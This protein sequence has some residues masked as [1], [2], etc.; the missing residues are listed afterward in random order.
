MD[1]EACPT[2]GTPYAVFRDLENKRWRFLCTCE[3][4]ARCSKGKHPA[5]HAKLNAGGDVE[6]FACDDHGV[7][8]D[9]R[10]PTPVMRARVA[11]E[12]APTRK[13]SPS[14]PAR[15]AHDL[16][17]LEGF[18]ADL[19]ERN[20]RGRCAKCGRERAMIDSDFRPVKG[21]PLY[22]LHCPHCGHYGHTFL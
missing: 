11:L 20:V 17:T 10:P 8:A 13:K 22:D 21:T 7:P 4:Q 9:E 12:A 16:L 2:C 14:A 18:R 1:D 3:G 15:P 6:R 5:T 19:A